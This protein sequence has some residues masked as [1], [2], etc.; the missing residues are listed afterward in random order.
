MGRSHLSSH[1]AYRLAMRD[2]AGMVTFSRMVAHGASGISPATAA[3]PNDDVVW[4]VIVLPAGV[5]LV[6]RSGEADFGPFLLTETEPDERRIDLVDR[7][8]TFALESEP[9]APGVQAQA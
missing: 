1:P 8:L 6:A 5:V 9:P 3:Q 4:Q 2:A 7:Q